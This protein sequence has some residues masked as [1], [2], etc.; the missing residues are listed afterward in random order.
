[1]ERD[2]KTPTIKKNVLN[3][4]HNENII[5]KPGF[6]YMVRTDINGEEIPGTG[7]T[8]SLKT[9]KTSFEH[10]NFKIKKKG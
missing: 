6:V 3:D 7:A 5:L 4:L 2:I 9:F 10:L 8:T 1:M